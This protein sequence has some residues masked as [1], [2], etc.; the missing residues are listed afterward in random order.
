MEELIRNWGYIILFLYSF[1]GGFLALGVAGVL[2]ASGEL[3][4]YIAI[5]V[6]LSA[7]FIGDEFLFY[8]ARNNKEF[9]REI[10]DKHKRKVAYV[11]VLMRRY[12][13]F[14][15]LIKKYIYGVKTLVPLAIGLTKYNH[16]K[17]MVFNAI[18]A[19]LWA[20]VVGGVTYSFG[21]AILG[22]AEEYKF[23]ALGG[24]I[25]IIVI[26]YFLMNKKS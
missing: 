16:A 13:S 20:V 25:G 10:M 17:F 1:G 2:S 15:I 5:L 4:I 14:I 7:N 11:H 23:Y 6:A 9:A 3:N 19:I 12:G 26:V 21:N 8:M 18:G 24:A 22:V